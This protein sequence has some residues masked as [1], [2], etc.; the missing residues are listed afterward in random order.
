L[1]QILRGLGWVLGLAL[2]LSCLVPAP[3]WAARRPPV[4][5]VKLTLEVV[6]GGTLVIQ[7]D[8]ILTPGH[9]DLPEDLE[10][11][12]RA[13]RRQGLLYRDMALQ[14]TRVEA[15]NGAPVA[16][17]VTRTPN[18]IWF[19]ISDMSRNFDYGPGFHVKTVLDQPFDN[20]EFS[21]SFFG[22]DN[23]RGGVAMVEVEIIW[24]GP[25]RSLQDVRLEFSNRGE[26]AELELVE[27]DE[28]RLLYRAAGRDMRLPVEV[29]VKSIA[30]APS[31]APSRGG[32][33]ATINR[34][35]SNLWFFMSFGFLGAMVLLAWALA[36]EGGG[37]FGRHTSR[38]RP[39]SGMEPGT[40]SVLLYGGI[41]SRFFTSSVLWFAHRGKVQ[42]EYRAEAADPLTGMTISK[43][44]DPDASF[45]DYE[46]LLWNNLLFEGLDSNSLHRLRLELGKRA[47]RHRLRAQLVGF[48]PVR[49]PLLKPQAREWWLWSKPYQ[50]VGGLIVGLAVMILFGWLG[51]LLPEVAK[52]DWLI[53]WPLMAGGGF[54]FMAKAHWQRHKPLKE[55][56]DLLGFAGFLAKDSK[57]MRDLR[58]NVSAFSLLLPF[59]VATGNERNLIDAYT[60][61]QRVVVMPPWFMV[62][63]TV[64]DQIHA[65]VFR[66]LMGDFIEGMLDSF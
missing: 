55:D 30:F 7:Q 46:R 9:P 64:G 31:V 49:E 12:I 20:A 16:H 53:T 43:R 44:M 28:S 5:K 35:W 50:V 45:K 40:A 47:R 34:L 38:T 33:T 13:V 24:S 14:N 22:Q 11:W 10:T 48:F 36:R 62:Y 59:A 26:D 41:S 51:L 27:K 18:G 42:L 57:T 65:N 29:N 15:L 17:E 54:L 63:G 25:A 60:M 21:S 19:T 23:I 4:E 66:E 56:S 8:Y 32:T 61:E 52:V 37:R 58:G 1:A 6:P 3:A 2:A 39:P